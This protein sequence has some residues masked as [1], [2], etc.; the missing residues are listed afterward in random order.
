MGPTRNMGG[1]IY[2][3]DYIMW[4]WD[5]GHCYEFLQTE[6]LHFVL[7]VERFLEQFL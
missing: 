4:K 5:L 3:K 1:V 2:S 7:L 6:A